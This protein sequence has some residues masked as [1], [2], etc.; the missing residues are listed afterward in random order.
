M[1]PEPKQSTT[2]PRGY[3]PWFVASIAFFITCLITANIIAVKLF[4]MVGLVLPAAIIIFPLSY[5]QCNVLAK[6]Y[7]YAQACCCSDSEKEL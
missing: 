6:A 7:G 1:P 3:F 2:F 5:I 4:T